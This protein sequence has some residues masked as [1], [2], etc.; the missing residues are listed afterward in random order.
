MYPSD[1]R[2]PI[3]GKLTLWNGF[4]EWHTWFVFFFLWSLY[5]EVFIKFGASVSQVYCVLLIFI[6]WY[7]AFLWELKVQSCP[8]EITFCSWLPVTYEAGWVWFQCML[9]SMFGAVKSS[10]LE[11]RKYGAVTLETLI[12]NSSSADDLPQ[13]LQQVISLL[14]FLHL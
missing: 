11:R 14:Q 10:V 4:F 3:W 7:I 1:Q 2:F 5:G 6:S 8:Y 13:G 12:S 9:L